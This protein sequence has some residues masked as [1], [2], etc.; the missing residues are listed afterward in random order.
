[1]KNKLTRLS[2]MMLI[3]LI[4]FGA[5]VLLANPF[6]F[7]SSPLHS[8]GLFQNHGGNSNSS[9][10]SGSN[11][12]ISQTPIGGQPSPQSSGSDDGGTDGR[13]DDVITATLLWLGR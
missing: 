11:S 2:I 12:G 5:V 7:A 10:P 3:G 1:M 6:N 13:T 4:A 9:P 8:I